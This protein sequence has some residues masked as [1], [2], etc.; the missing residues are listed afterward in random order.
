MQA[1]INAVPAPIFFKDREGRY[2]GCNH[3]FEDYVGMTREQLVGH[4]VFELFDPELA[5]TD[6][7]TQVDSRFSFTRSAEAAIA[8]VNRT[9]SPVS[10]LLLDLDNFKGIN[11]AHGHLT[12]DAILLETARRLRSTIRKTDKVGRLGGDEF[13]IL[14]Q[15]TAGTERLEQIANKLIAIASEPIV[16]PDAE[17]CIGVSI[18]VASAPDH[19]DDL[20]GLMRCADRALYRAKAVGKSCFHIFRDGQS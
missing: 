3:A 4:T 18:G 8:L 19:A 16:T 20:T 15:D 2:L 17:V 7:V 12:G 5:L 10:L 11:D 14:L 6:T 13:A 9:A 1:V